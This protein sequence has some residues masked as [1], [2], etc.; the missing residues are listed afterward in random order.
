VPI[1][2]GGD[3][4][5]TSQPL[6]QNGDDDLFVLP[7]GWSPDFEGFN[8]HEIQINVP[9]KWRNEVDSTTLIEYSESCDC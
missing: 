5:G 8:V 1:Y 4:A 7:M 3:Q 6:E 9:V 2:E